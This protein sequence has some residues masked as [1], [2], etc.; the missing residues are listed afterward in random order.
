MDLIGSPILIAVILVI[1]CTMFTSVMLIIYCF[2]TSDNG[3]SDLSHLANVQDNASAGV[4]STMILLPLEMEYEKLDEGGGGEERACTVCLSDLTDGDVVRRL[5]ECSHYFHSGC[6]DE[7]LRLRG[8]CPTCRSEALV[9]PSEQR[10]VE[11]PVAAGAAARSPD[12]F[13]EYTSF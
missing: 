13:A 5:P 1:I 12:A 2:S 4:R 9:A 7:W 11:G 8:S 3:G 10:G 6:I